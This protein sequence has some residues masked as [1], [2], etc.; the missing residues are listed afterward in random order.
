[1]F[2][3]AKNIEINGK[4]VKSITLENGG[5]LYKK[6]DEPYFLSVTSDKDTLSYHD[7]DSAIL[8]ARLTKGRVRI[9]GEE[10]RFYVVEDVPAGLSFTGSYF[11]PDSEMTE[12][13]KGSNI[14]IDWGDGSTTTYTHTG[15]L[16]HRYSEDKDYFI[17][18]TG[19]T[20]IEHGCFATCSGLTSVV[21]PESVTSLGETCFQNN[22]ELTS[23]VIPNSIS[24]LP[25][26]CFY[27]CVN[28]TSV[29]IPE[30]VTSLGGSCFRDCPSLTTI[31][32]PEGVTRLGASCFMD[33]SGL[34]S[35][36]IPKSVTTI[37]TACFGGCSDLTNVI[38]NWTTNPPSFVRPWI[39]QNSIYK[40]SIPNG[41]TQVY[42]DAGYPS[43]KLV[44]RSE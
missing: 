28:L 8:S 4:T 18:I 44:E 39:T 29:V 16:S 34:T 30:S 20:S 10:V 33:C 5:I 25:D 17:I 22:S 2:S 13:L 9:Q 24:L 11:Y 42:I 21:I 35:V 26:Y 38:C 27:D 19:V 3:N 6:E 43:N 15:D 37:G 7:N 41:T 36:V 31:V 12:G 40:F 23:V 1:M 14:V 32:I